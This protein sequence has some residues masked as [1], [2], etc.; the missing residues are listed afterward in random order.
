MMD[1]GMAVQ[2]SIAG[3]A[4][5]CNKYIPCSPKSIFPIDHTSVIEEQL[6]NC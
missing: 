4:Q 5:Y 3:H 6:L 2:L 1:L